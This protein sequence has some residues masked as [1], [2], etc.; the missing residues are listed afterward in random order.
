MRCSLFT[1]PASS[2]TSQLRAQALALLS[3]I[4][5]QILSTHARSLTLFSQ[6]SF[7]FPWLLL[8]AAQKRQ[9]VAARI[10]TPSSLTADM[11]CWE[12]S[13]SIR[14]LSCPSEGRGGSRQRQAGVAWQPRAQAPSLWQALPC[15]LY[16]STEEH[17]R[18][19]LS[20]HV[21][22]WGGL[23]PPTL[24]LLFLL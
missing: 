3:N 21:C 7:K 2:A 17:T 24:P 6:A 13:S 4:S 19:M 14:S 11:G 5:I 10:P 9:G 18:Q 20:G 8:S 1:C 22:R 23:S 12:S 16:S 15:S